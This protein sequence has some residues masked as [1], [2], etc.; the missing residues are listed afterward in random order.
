MHED[1]M[2]VADAANRIFTE[3]CPPE[4]VEQAE[5]GIYATGLWEILNTNG[6]LLAGVDEANGGSGGSIID[7]LIILREAARRAAPLPLA[8]TFIA[9]QVL[10]HLQQPMPALPITLVQGNFE[11]SPSGHL[12]GASSRV[13]FGRNCQSFLIAV[14]GANRQAPQTI[15]LC[16]VDAGQVSIEQGNNISGEPCDHL[17]IETEVIESHVFNLDRQ[18]LNY[19][20]LLGAAGRAVMMAG[21]LEEMLQLTV[22]YA[23]ERHQF[24]KAIAKFQ[25]I[26]QQLAVFAGEVAASKRAADTL[27]ESAELNALDVAIAKARIGEASGIS[28]EI[29]HQ[30][31]GAIGYTR[32]HRLNQLTRRLWQ[33]RDEFGNENYWQ[34]YVAEIFLNDAAGELWQEITELKV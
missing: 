8:E 18:W 33:W 11:L 12:N 24:G 1:Q 3:E 10:N 31:H 2:L 4:V 16:L 22:D 21:A 23:L 25:A 17:S 6:L 29:A 5:S 9:G 19:A 30:V 15:S 20:E 27:L 14:N 34:H 32:E 13:P 7:A 28:A 26:Q